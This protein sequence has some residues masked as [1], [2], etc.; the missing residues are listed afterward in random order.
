MSVSG[1]KTRAAHP[2]EGYLGYQLRRAA[3]FMQTDMSVRLS[4]LDLTMVEMSILLVVEANPQITQSQI[5]R[6]L[7][8]KRANM[9]PL[10]GGLQAR[11][12]LDRQP[13]DGRSN[14]LILTPAG[15]GMT[16]ACRVRIEENEALLLRNISSRARDPLLASLGRIWARE[17]NP[18]NPEK[19]ADP[20]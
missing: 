19:E 5:C 10:A 12:L 14:G 1:K 7:A 17:Q 18:D 13:V 2:L 9:A 15:A 3:A 4:E 16:D 8:I 11:G 6:M 20:I